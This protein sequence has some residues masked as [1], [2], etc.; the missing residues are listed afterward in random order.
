MGF[1]QFGNR[2]I[3][4]KGVNDQVCR[5]AAVKYLEAGPSVSRHSRG[6]I[7]ARESKAVPEFPRD[8]F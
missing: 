6:V 2:D 5:V 3:P 1:D 7:G 4:M 8:R